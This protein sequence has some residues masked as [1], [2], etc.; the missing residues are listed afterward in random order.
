MTV[1]LYVDFRPSWMQLME[2]P[3]GSLEARSRMEDLARNA[4]RQFVHQD[5][6]TVTAIDDDGFTFA[7]TR[8]RGAAPTKAT[9]P[10][11]GGF[12]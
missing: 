5:S 2:A 7:V 12:L 8:W 3:I 6:I 11:C 10:H 9:C 1:R 4:L